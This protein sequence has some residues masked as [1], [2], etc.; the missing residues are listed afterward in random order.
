MSPRRAEHHP[1][2]AGKPPEGPEPGRDPTRLPAGLGDLCSNEGCFGV[3]NLVNFSCQVGVLREGKF[4]LVGFGAGLMIKRTWTDQLEKKTFGFVPVYGRM[5]VPQR[6][7]T[8]RSDPRRKVLE[9]KNLDLS[10]K[11]TMNL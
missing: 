11:E 7:E 2:G 9:S 8:Q 3:A 5:G 4:P 10:E 1:E 6:H